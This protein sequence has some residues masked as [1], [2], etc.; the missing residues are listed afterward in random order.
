MSP[1]PTAEREFLCAGIEKLR[2]VLEMVGFRYEPGDV[3]VSCGGA[4]A[5][6]FF[7]RGDLEIGLIVRSRNELGTPNYTQ[8]HGYASH[9]DLFRELGHD[10]EARLVPG[11]FPSHVARD[12]SDPFDA[13]EGDLRNTILPALSASEVDFREAIARAHR[14]H[15]DELLR[16]LRGNVSQ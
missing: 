15:M 16:G 13:L 8:G 9:E 12:G 2:A 3:G 5:A 4:F 14:K 6:G 11:D 10:G 1:G 7:R